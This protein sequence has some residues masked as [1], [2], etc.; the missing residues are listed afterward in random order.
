[1]SDLHDRLNALIAHG[2]EF[3]LVL[4]DLPVGIAKKVCRG[5]YEGEY[6]VEVE[7]KEFS[8]PID[9]RMNQFTMALFGATEAEIE[10]VAPNDFFGDEFQ[11]EAENAKGIRNQHLGIIVKD[12]MGVHVS[13]DMDLIRAAN[14]DDYV[15]YDISG[16]IWLHH[17][18]MD[19]EYI[20]PNVN[21]I[22]KMEE[23]D[24]GWKLLGAE[25]II[26]WDHPTVDPDSY[27]VLI[28]KTM[29]QMPWEYIDTEGN[30]LTHDTKVF[31][32]EGGFFKIVLSKQV[33]ESLDEQTAAMAEQS[34]VPHSI[35]LGKKATGPTMDQ[36]TDF[37][38]RVVEFTFTPETLSSILGDS[39]KEGI[40]TNQ[41][42]SAVKTWAVTHLSRIHADFKYSDNAEF[43]GWL[44]DYIDDA[45]SPETDVQIAVNE[46]GGA[47]EDEDQWDAYKRI[48]KEK[49][50]EY[51]ESDNP[52]I[53]V[54]RASSIDPIKPE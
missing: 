44:N 12:E 36:Y 11:E 47:R 10:L 14:F 42:I 20:D 41:A 38:K 24:S 54:Y 49:I 31:Q 37:L 13:S 2:K 50:F 30:T 33:R 46:N 17:K 19:L 53:M 15:L 29:V 40:D 18:V 23:A 4:G 21:T 43:E 1:M 39:L 32:S 9:V 48:L 34:L 28:P 7:S 6:V 3:Q 16:A 5:N 27:A 51:R 45:I 26:R 25:N 52:Q 8:R 22:E 35:L